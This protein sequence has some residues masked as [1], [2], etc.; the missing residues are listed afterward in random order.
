MRRCERTQPSAAIGVKT[1]AAGPM[2]D[3]ANQSLEIR[4]WEVGGIRRRGA[5]WIALRRGTEPRL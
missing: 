3:Q 5:Q 4:R 1:D 2:S